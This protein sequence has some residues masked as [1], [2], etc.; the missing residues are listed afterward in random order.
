MK[1]G[2]NV[3]NNADDKQVDRGSKTSCLSL[4]E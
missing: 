2:F 3:L 4:S 1:I